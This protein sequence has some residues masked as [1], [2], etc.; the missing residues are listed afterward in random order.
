LMEARAQLKAGPNSAI[1]VNRTI[2]MLEGVVESGS[3]AAPEE[4]RDKVSEYY[5]ALNG[6]L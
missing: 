4:F 2:D 5:K 1:P 3:D 6:A